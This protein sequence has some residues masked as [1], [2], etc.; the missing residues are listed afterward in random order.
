[1]LK[2]VEAVQLDDLRFLYYSKLSFLVGT[3]HKV[4]Q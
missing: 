1:M 2:F 3:L 4:V